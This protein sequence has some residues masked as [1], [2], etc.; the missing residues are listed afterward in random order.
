LVAA[1]VQQAS[2]GLFVGREGGIFITNDVRD[3][4]YGS[5]WQNRL[6]PVELKLRDARFSALAASAAHHPTH[7]LP[8]GY[9]RMH[10]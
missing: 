6:Q 10:P 4:L 2:T 9:K 3:D 1:C 7:K 5:P 8:V